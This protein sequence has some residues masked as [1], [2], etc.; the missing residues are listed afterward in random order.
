MDKTYSPALTKQIRVYTLGGNDSIFYGGVHS[1]I[2]VRV[3][4]AEGSKK[5][6]LAPT[7]KALRLYGRTDN[8]TLSGDL[9]SV[10]QHR[11]ND[12]ANTNFHPVN[13]Y[14]LTFPLINAGLN[15]DDGFL[16]GG[17]FR[18]LRQKGFR[19]EPYSAM[20][21]LMLTHSFS[22]DAFKLAFHSEWI[23]AIGK[24]DIVLST[25]VNKPNN[26]INFFGLGNE[27]E[28]V[29]SNGIKYYRTRFSTYELAPALRWRGK[30]DWSVSV[31]PALQYYD[32]E[33][34]D[35][36]GRFINQQ[37]L[38]GTYDSTTIDKSKLHLG[39]K[40]NF[41]YD[42]RKGAIL[43]TSGILVSATLTA[44]KG[45]G[46]YTRDYGQF[47]PEFSFYQSL[48]AAR[49]LVI[50]DRIGGIVSL[51]HPAFYQAAFLGGQGNLLGYRQYR[52]AGRNAVFNNFELRL[53]LA[54]VSS[55]IFPG[56]LGLSGF[57][58]IGRVWAYNDQSDTWHNGQGGGIYY[59]PAQLVVFKLIAGHSDE[60]W[61]PYISMGMR[62]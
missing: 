38:I 6:G 27:T 25:Q 9:S 61:Y 24:A 20:Y 3:I 22:T 29:K 1:A 41:T 46:D 57:F 44:Y 37:S 17:G 7:N 39:G 10:R 18:F 19:Q 42:N 54:D 13:L 40:L 45:T 35:N 32:Y 56:E 51:G 5:I 4:T 31:G 11:S 26:T 28:Y 2:T 50:S 21:Q 8:I 34:D 15:S 36:K 55:Y 47:T 30:K 48:N 53:K 62:F 59:A 14:N 33:A 60:G 23:R 58:D 49:T 16:F 12:T 43:P 52:F